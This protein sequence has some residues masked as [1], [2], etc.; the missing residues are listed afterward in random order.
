MI[1][2]GRARIEGTE[3]DLKAVIVRGLSVEANGSYLDY[4][5]LSLGAAAG[6]VGGPTLTTQ[7][8]YV[9][10]CRDPLVQ[11]MT[12]PSGHMDRSRPAPTAH[13]GRRCIS[14]SPIRRPARRGVWP[15]QRAIGV[16]QPER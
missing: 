2:A 10:R 11:S 16:D 9:P 8:P 5:T 3:A 6:Q 7:P 4:K 1:N 13:I 14:I 15:S 12:T